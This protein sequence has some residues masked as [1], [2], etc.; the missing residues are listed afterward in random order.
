MEFLTSAPEIKSH[1]EDKFT[2]L[3]RFPVTEGRKDEGGLRTKGLYKK[4]IPGVPFLTIIT[5][6]YNGKAHIEETIQS[7][8]AQKYESFEYIIID[9]GSTDGTV[10]I[11]KKYDDSIDYWV[12]EK[13]KGIS[14][15]FNKGIIAARGDLL[16]FQ[17][18]GD[19]FLAPDVLQ[20][21]MKGVTPDIQLVCG[22][23]QRTDEN[24]KPL[25]ES[26]N[27]THFSK[28]S[29]LF[30]MSLPHQGLFT[31]LDFFK[32]YGLFDKACKFAMDYEHLL[33]AY[34]NF[35]QVITSPVVVAKWRA[36]GVGEG[37]TEAVLAEYDRIKR[38]NNVASE[39]ILNLL[40][41][42]TMSK[43]RVK[44]LLKRG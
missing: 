7:I 2:S 42:W 29:L 31:H 44:K 27:I 9:G 5:V 30:K 6:V 37:R 36:D 15:A 35:P 11:L 32:K 40:H 18:D 38:M 17:G 34:K 28:T 16:N 22:R 8:I 12:S 41:F 21:L 10:D 14:D 33:R 3:L 4:K 25:F 24:G 19:G 13:D 26:P 1:P 23:I 39:P 43:Y 20:K